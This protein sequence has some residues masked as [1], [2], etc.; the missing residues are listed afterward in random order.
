MNRWN[1]AKRKQHRVAVAID[2]VG[3]TAMIDCDPRVRLGFGECS[4]MNKL[5]GKHRWNNHEVVFGGVFPYRCGPTIGQPRG[6]DSTNAEQ[7]H[8]GNSDTARWRL[9]KCNKVGGGV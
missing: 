6:L 8:S 2:H 9:A 4:K 3:E 1:V 5:I 7:T